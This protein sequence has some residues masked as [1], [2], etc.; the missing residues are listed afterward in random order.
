M[1]PFSTP[2][3]LDGEPT[4]IGEFLEANYDG[5][6]DCEALCIIMTLTEDGIYEGGGGAQPVFFLKVE[7]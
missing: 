7:G 6:T 4:T 5:F 1:L 2:I 3:T